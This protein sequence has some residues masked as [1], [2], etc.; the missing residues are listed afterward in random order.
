MIPGYRAC[1]YKYIF[2]LSYHP[3]PHS[4]IVG[5]RSA[6][7]VPAQGVSLK[8]IWLKL[9]QLVYFY[10]LLRDDFLGFGLSCTPSAFIFLTGF[11]SSPFSSLC[12]GRFVFDFFVGGGEIAALG[13]DIDFSS[14]SPSFPMISL[15][16]SARSTSAAVNSTHYRHLT[17]NQYHFLR[18][19]KFLESSQ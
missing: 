1:K 17:K 2:R 8:I 11:N 3:D 7:H 6:F 13:L 15:V 12:S 9:W 18:F 14:P 10:F 16:N 5:S 4:K 19:S